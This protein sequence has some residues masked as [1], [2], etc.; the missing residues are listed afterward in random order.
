MK[1]FTRGLL[2]L[3]SAA[4]L[5]AL[6][7][8]P[9]LAQE[10]GQ[11]GI[12]IEGNSQGDVKTMNPILFNDVY[13]RRVINLMFP[14]LIA[15]DPKAGLYAK[16][17]PDGLAK[18]WAIS[19][20]GKTYT[21]TLRDD[22]KW[23]DGTPI[24]SAD[25]LFSYNAVASGKTTSPRTS[26]LAFIDSVEA[27]DAHT[28]VIHFKTGACNNI[29]NATSIRPVPSA[30]FKAQ[31]GDD[32]SKMNDMDFNKNP[33]V[34]A[35]PFKFS[36]FRA[37]EQ[38]SMEANQDYPDT[39]KGYVNPTGYIYKNVPDATVAVQQL[40]AGEVNLLGEDVVPQEQFADLRS[41]AKNGDIQVFE[42]LDLGYEWMALNLADPA[43][44]QNG[45]DKDGKPIDQGHHPIFGD[46][47]VRNALAM[48][49]DLDAV[50]KGALFGEAVPIASPG[51]PASWSYNP[52]LKPVAY[53][54]EGA[55]KLLAEAGWTDQDG[56]GI[57]EAHGAKYAKD[58]TP[59]HFQLIVSSGEPTTI[60]VGTLI[61]DQL[62]KIGVDVDFQAITFNTAVEKLI[63]QTYDA[64][65][66]GWSL[67]FPDDPDFKFA[68]DAQ[69][70]VVGGGF[71]F[72]SYNNPDV[73]K[74]LDQANNLPG[75]DQQARAKLYQQ[76]QALLAKDNPYIWLYT[77]KHL[78]VAGKNVDGFAPYPQQLLW[79]VDSWAIKS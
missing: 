73:I 27:P 63:G 43:N 39:L 59:L 26:A 54:P 30:A 16:G 29:D 40:L 50:I 44:P 65:I 61:Q 70:D 7:V 2:F 52:D 60:A 37:G 35:G 8:L 10:G 77:T 57:L 18:D 25:Y 41:R 17:A 11:G 38:T 62:K 22:W 53:D 34:T 9:A 4:L 5:G 71:D 32:F 19:D 14:Y 69:N 79:N 72:T 47:R 46:V 68:F 15:V 66:L 20:D 23:S 28:L 48:G 45:A 49:I 6:V 36:E 24:T 78:W 12:I 1:H 21:F 55:K 33:T 75:C 64:I 3:I 13:S 42:N 58:G 31:I 51:T 56:N 76:A 67:T 74:L